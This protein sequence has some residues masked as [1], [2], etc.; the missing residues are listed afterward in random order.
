MLAAGAGEVARPRDRDRTTGR[1]LVDH[2]ASEARH[3]V[4][5]EHRL[6]A[7]AHDIAALSQ[8]SDELAIYAVL[9]LELRGT[10]RLQWILRERGARAQP[11][12][13]LLF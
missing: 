13:L 10:W 1:D 4:W 3:R 2:R 12:T 6:G 11:V 5:K 8:R 7:D 9:G